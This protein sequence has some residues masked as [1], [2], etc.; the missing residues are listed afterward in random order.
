MPERK[1][2]LWCAMKTSVKTKFHSYRFFLQLKI[3]VRH[4]KKKPFLRKLANFFFS[5]RWVL[6]PPPLTQT[7][8]HH[9]RSSFS[10]FDY[11]QVL[12]FLSIIFS[13]PIFRPLSG[14]I[15]KKPGPKVWFLLV[16]FKPNF[17]FSKSLNLNFLIRSFWVKSNIIGL[18]YTACA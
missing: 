13:S 17:I 6:I 5:P 15:V 10:C 7:K 14:H 1:Y 9:F 8:I 18:L 2:K 16:D 3:S 4:R 12:Q 11:K